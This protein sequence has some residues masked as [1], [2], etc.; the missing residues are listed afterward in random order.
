MWKFK[1]H[2]VPTELYINSELSLHAVLEVFCILMLAI[3]SLLEMIGIVC[4]CKKTKK[5]RN[6]FCFVADLLESIRRFKVLHYLLDLWNVIDWLHMSLMWIAWSLWIHQYQVLNSF[7]MS[8]RYEILEDT[9]ARARLFKTQADQEF[10]FLQFSSNL[11]KMSNNLEQYI[12]VSSICGM[13]V[14]L[15][16][17]FEFS[18]FL[19]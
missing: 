3:N 5:F 11:M 4:S 12:S 16:T 19:P 1:V 15:P 9:G 8:P 6:N 13:S 18:G 14:L 7:S 10:E 17:L 2:S